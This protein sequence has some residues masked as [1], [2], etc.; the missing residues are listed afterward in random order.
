M[1]KE[2][3]HS[4]DKTR[5]TKL[6][7]CPKCSKR[8]LT[9]Y[10]CCKSGDYLADYVGRCNR[11]QNCAYHY[12]PKQYFEENPN[13]KSFIPLQIEEKQAIV[14]EI[15]CIPTKYFEGALT[16]YGHNNFV[17]FLETLFGK[18]LSKYL[19]ERF[20][21]GT[22]KYWK[23]ASVFW[24]IDELGNIRTGK[25]MLY[26]CK[27]GK[28]IKTPYNHVNWVHSILKLE[29]Y[30]LQ[31]CLFGIWQLKNAT[32][33]TTV[34]IVESEK[35]AIVMSA[36]LPKCIWLATGGI[37]NLKAENCQILRHRTVVLYPD[38][39]GFEKWKNK[40]DEL[41]NICKFVTTSDLLDRNA[42]EQ[43]H[44]EGF[45]LADYFLKK[46]DPKS[47]LLITDEGYPAFWD[48]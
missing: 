34:C 36:I 42:T 38:L 33:D 45:D 5:P 4:L 12:T 8:V 32:L 39:G 20:H 15:S 28:R 48:W 13:A 35:T 43:D 10:V 3:T 11:E 16:A 30:H 17:I 1:I 37:N 14:K 44:K 26:D 41:Q 29:N 21:I 6:F 18:A 22:S 47:G 7:L 24:Q 40:A 2:Y 9:R 25:V 46:Q 27:L 19:I 23:G 31:Q